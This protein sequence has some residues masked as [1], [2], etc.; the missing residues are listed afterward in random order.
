MSE[1]VDCEEVKEEEEEEKET[2][3]VVLA[4]VTATVHNKGV[5]EVHRD[6]KRGEGVGIEVEEEEE[7][8]MY[9]FDRH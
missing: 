7:E 2:E 6:V 3:A 4:K 1:G 9:Y 5:L 8:S